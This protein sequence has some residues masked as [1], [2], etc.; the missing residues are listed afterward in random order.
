MRRQGADPGG[1][2]IGQDFTEYK[3]MVKAVLIS[4]IWICR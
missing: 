3:A 1:D 2:V 4:V